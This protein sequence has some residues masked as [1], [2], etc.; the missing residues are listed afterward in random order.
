MPQT[1]VPNGR[2]AYLARVRCGGHSMIWPSLRISAVRL[3]KNSGIR[4]DKTQGDRKMWTV[5]T[6]ERVIATALCCAVIAV[7]VVLIFEIGVL[8][9]RTLAGHSVG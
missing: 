2:D 6:F 3:S 8:I 9:F 5:K 4:F 7:V 1:G